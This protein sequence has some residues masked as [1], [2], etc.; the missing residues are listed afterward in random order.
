[1]KKTVLVFGNPYLAGDDMAVKVAEGMKLPGVVFR[2]CLKAEEIL[3]HLGESPL[4]ILD[5]VKGL[6]KVKTFKDVSAFKSKESI[7]VHD[8]DAGF[9]LR[10][11]KE[12][13]NLA[14]V[15]IIG[16]PEK[17]NNKSIKKEVAELLLNS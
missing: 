1:M 12:S 5:T 10:I 7:T 8:L 6:K 4:Y 15:K 17:G 2:H 14:G 11:L 3:D 13:S 9:L 16:V